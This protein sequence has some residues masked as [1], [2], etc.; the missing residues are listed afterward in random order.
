ML[1][2]NRIS[3]HDM[4]PLIACAC[5]LQRGCKYVTT[6]CLQLSSHHVGGYKLV[7]F[8]SEHCLLRTCSREQRTGKMETHAIFTYSNLFP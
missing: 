7:V 3:V 6:A 5:V 1:T 4:S 8:S 2:E